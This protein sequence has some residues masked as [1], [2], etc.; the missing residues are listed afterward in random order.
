MNGGRA[1]RIEM[2][3]DAGAAALFAAASAYALAHFTP[4][5]AVGAAAGVLAFWAA[6]GALR[7]VRADD[8]G[9]ALADFSVGEVTPEEADELVLTDAD[10]LNASTSDELVLEDELP[11]PASDSQVVRLFDP[12]AMPAPGQLQARI[13]RHL[14]EAGPPTAP[15][16]ASQALQEALADLRRSLR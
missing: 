5:A 2:L 1:E 9:F 4:I 11:Q 16:D 12:S 13:D 8:P 6:L 14:S 15:P 10:R 3:V 7:R